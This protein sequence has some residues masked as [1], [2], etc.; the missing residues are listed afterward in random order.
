MRYLTFKFEL[1]KYNVKTILL[2]VKQIL[3]LS[4]IGL[5]FSCNTSSTV[6]API[7]TSYFFKKFKSS[8]YHI[9]P[10]GDYV[11]YLTIKE[12]VAN[13]VIENLINLKKSQITNFNAGGVKSYFWAND[14]TVFYIANTSFGQELYYTNSNGLINKSVFKAKKIDFIAN[15]IWNERRVLLSIQ[16]DSSSNSNAYSVDIRTWKPKLICNNTGNIIK[17]KADNNGM[18]RI[19]IASDGLNETILFKNSVK[20]NFKKLISSNFINSIRPIKFTDDNKKFYALSNMGSNYSSLVTINCANGLVNKVIKNKVDVLNV[21][22]ENNY[23]TQLEIEGPKKEFLFLNNDWKA[24]Y[25]KLKENLNSPY[26]KILETDNSGNNYLIK[27]YSDIHEDTYYIYNKLTEKVIF[28]S[29]KGTMLNDR[30]CS[31]KPIKFVNAD[32]ITLEGYLTLPKGD[33]YNLPCVVLLHSTTVDRNVW[34]YLPDVQF[35]A[36]RGY[37]VL[38][39]NYR[40][41]CDYGKSLKISGFK[42]WSKLMQN[43]IIDGAKWLSDTKI[44]N[45]KKIAIFGY[46]FGGFCALNAAFDRPDIFNCAASYSGIN[47]L[48]SYMKDY[49]LYGKPYQQMLNQTIGNPI[50]DASYLR[51]VS[52]IFNVN[53]V[54]IP[55]FIVQGARD[56]FVNVNETNEFVKDVRKKNI[57]VKYILKDNEGHKFVD[58]KNI[59]ELYNSLDVFLKRNFN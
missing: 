11:S 34:G 20:E 17:W 2:I 24:I 51:Q 52:P 40:G 55:L 22:F 21:N 41:S 46:D 33:K 32:G 14:N 57:E 56:K 47:N 54:K 4:C 25:I 3:L 58:N 19:A 18:I 27:L 31:M 50:N 44:A 7:P 10:K 29:N 1:F 23:P 59:I 45:P 6:E 39:I 30:L 15:K 13:I 28:L 53:K 49:T 37:A 8:E 42:N 35:L 12:N 5:F 48:F 16:N 38:Q 36:N 9:S 43:D 26:I